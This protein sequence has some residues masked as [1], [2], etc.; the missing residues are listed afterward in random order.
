[1]D[2]KHSIPVHAVAA[3]TDDENTTITSTEALE[4]AHH[5]GK[6]VTLATIHNWITSK[7]KLRLQHQPKGAGGRHYIYKLAFLRFITGNDGGE[8]CQK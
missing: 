8:E 2:S 1:M 4:V 6:K 7:K 3:P 5:F